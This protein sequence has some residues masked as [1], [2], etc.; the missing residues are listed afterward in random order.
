MENFMKKEKINVNFGNKIRRLREDGGFIQYDFAYECEISDAYY[1]RLERG[2][3]SPSL[4]LMY[5]IAKTLG[6]P[7]SELLKD[8]D[9]F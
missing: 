8:V 7:L 2:E 4:K 1:G 9:M 3:F 6:L 5:K